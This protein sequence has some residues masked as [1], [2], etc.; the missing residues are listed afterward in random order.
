[1]RS[2][3]AN[4][5][6]H[7]GGESCAGAASLGIG[8]LS[9]HGYETLRATLVSLRQPGFLELFNEHVVFF[10]EITDE[11][12]ALAA[13]FGFESHGLPDNKGIMEGFRGLASSMS[14]TF[15]IMLE[16][17]C[18]LIETVEEATSQ[19]TLARM[20][21]QSGRAQVIRLRSRREPGENFEAT[22]KYNRYYPRPEVSLQSRV[23]S[24]VLRAMRPYKARRLIGT[25]VYV[26]SKPEVR[27][28]SD[29]HAVEGGFYLLPT[30]VIPWTNQSIMIDRKF[31]LDKIIARSLSVSGRRQTNGYKNIEI[32]LNGSWWRK[33]PWKIAVAPGLFT[34]RRIGYRGY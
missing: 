17:D 19:I 6:L 27:F 14:S 29:V 30:A 32:E 34:H 3:L 12:R 4:G 8:I 22:R 7:G 5:I 9:W 24:V 13:E 23:G 18:P 16:N 33:Q 20:L 26:D 31:F 25:S 28:P 10:P 21:L 2:D 1:M 15:V 11:G